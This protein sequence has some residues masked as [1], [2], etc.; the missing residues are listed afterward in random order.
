MQT[1]SRLQNAMRFHGCGKVSG[2]RQATSVDQGTSGLVWTVVVS[3]LDFL[4]REFKGGKW[5]N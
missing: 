1:N 4:R 3:S 2:K 5:I